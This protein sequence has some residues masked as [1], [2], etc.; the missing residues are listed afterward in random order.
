MQP[1]P[2]V[3]FTYNRLLHT[4]ST[5]KSLQ[6]NDMAETSELIVFSDGP[7]LESDSGKVQAVREYLKTIAGFKRV[8]IIER[9]ENIGLAR[10]IIAGVTEIVEKNGRIIVLEDDMVTSPW[11]LRYMNEA[12]ELY[13]DE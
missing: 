7:K 6:K 2:I 13:Q 3:L 10:S 5:V 4:V 8:S 12:L 9:D 11:F 1:A